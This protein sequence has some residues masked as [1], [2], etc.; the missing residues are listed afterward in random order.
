MKNIIQILLL[1]IILFGIS[2]NKSENISSP[3]SPDGVGG[4]MARFTIVGNYLYVV[5][6][7]HLNTFSLAQPNDPQKVNATAVSF[8]IETIFPFQDKL[9]IGSRNG[10]FIYS[11]ANPASPAQLSMASHFTACDPVVA[12]ENYAYVTVRAGS[13]CGGQSNALIIYDIQSILQP[14]SVN[15]IPMT[16]PHGLGLKNNR[17]F[18]CD[19]A[20][21]LKVYNITSPQ[22]PVLSQHI[23]TGFFYDCIPYGNILICSIEGGIALYDITENQ[24]LSLLGT[25]TN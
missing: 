6:S 17:L 14:R 11:L 7:G 10:L 16:N 4:S 24:D 21:G 5:D 13:N 20:A 25:I 2:C 15:S 23:S 18:V 1:A 12:N 8:D 22:F 3:S 9:F 19:G